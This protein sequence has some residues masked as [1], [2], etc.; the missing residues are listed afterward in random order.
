MNLSEKKDYYRYGI[1]QQWCYKQPPPLSRDVTEAMIRLGLDQ[2]YRFIWLGVAV[3]RTEEVDLNP[4]V[5]GDRAACR[6][7]PMQIG[8]K[9]SNGVIVPDIVPWLEPKK[10]FVYARQ[11]D[12][13]YYLDDDGHQVKITRPEFA[14]PKK[15]VLF[16]DKFICYGQLRW[17]IEQRFTGQQLVDAGVYHH[18]QD[19]PS[20]EWRAIETIK[21]ADDT[22]AEP[23]M[24]HVERLQ[25][26]AF[27]GRNA[28]LSDVVREQV[29]TRIKRHEEKEAAVE[30]EAK[31]EWDRFEE[32]ERLNLARQTEYGF[33]ARA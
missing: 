32:S 17:R 14:P 31:A 30:A 29:L 10:V 20:E 33:A 28:H 21:A 23:E 5:L 4:V 27:E 13:M 25:Q 11:Q 15:T 22:Y 7:I 3:V 24:W 12:Y 19:V 18:S 9:V 6:F 8:T 26:F 16:R 2:D 1:Q